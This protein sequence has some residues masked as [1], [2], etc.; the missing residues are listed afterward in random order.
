VN[1]DLE[2]TAT[3]VEQLDE[4][5]DALNAQINRLADSLRALG[6]HGPLQVRVEAEG[7]VQ[8]LGPLLGH[9]GWERH[10]GDDFTL[11]WTPFGDFPG[12]RVLLTSTSINTR[13]AAIPALETLVA[14]LADATSQRLRCVR[15]ATATV[16]RLTAKVSREALR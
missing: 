3:T 12:T 7:D 4:A 2:G 6:V 11:C 5:L 13:L 16:A 14:R 8:G 10:A 1:V 15:T 9:V